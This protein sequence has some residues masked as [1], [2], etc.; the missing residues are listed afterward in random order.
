M[1]VDETCSYILAYIVIV[2]DVVPDDLQ[3]YAT[4][5]HLMGRFHRMWRVR[6]GNHRRILALALTSKKFLDPALDVLWRGLF[7]A[8][9]PEYFAV[10]SQESMRRAVVPGLTRFLS[11]T[12]SLALSGMHSDLRMDDLL[13]VARLRS[14]ASLTVRVEGDVWPALLDEHAALFPAL[15]RP[16]PSD[17]PS[18]HSSS[19]KS[20]PP[21]RLVISQI[22]LTPQPRHTAH[23]RGCSRTLRTLFINIT[24]CSLTPASFTSVARLTSLEHLR[25]SSSEH[26]RFS[27]DS[28][29]DT[30]GPLRNLFSFSAFS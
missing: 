2:A 18:S 27:D 9:L 10:F 6:L 29:L 30:T 28:F 17:T 7:A 25:F 22:E 13:S 19:P 12:S 14:I 8:A 15:P 26:V 21:T 24:E 1:T 20:L 4:Y 16:P 5:S 11:T 23:L 3:N